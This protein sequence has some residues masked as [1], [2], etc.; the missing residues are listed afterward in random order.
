[1][2]KIIKENWESLDKTG[3]VLNGFVKADNWIIREIINKADAQTSMLYLIILSH[4]NTQTGQCFPS[5]SLLSKEMGVS[6]STLKTMLN[7][8]Y[9]MGAIQIN[10]GRQGVAN[11]YYFPSEDF[12]EEFSGMAEGLATRRS[13]AFVSNKK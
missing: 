9:D 11:N 4:R 2:K 7:K 1:M 8:L 5:L 12:Y 6:L 13:K 3:F 10:T